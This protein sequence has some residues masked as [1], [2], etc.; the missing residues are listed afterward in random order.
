[1]PSLSE[2]QRR[3]A[4]NVLDLASEADA[5]LGV[6][7]HTI[8]ANYRSALGATYRVVRE[9]TGVPFFEAAVD[10]FVHAH[11]STGGDLNVYGDAFPAFLEA[12]P[13]AA[14]LPYLPDVAR[15]EWALDETHR[16]AD[17]GGSAQAT[18]A[19]LA[20][21]PAQDVARQR[22]ALHP[23]CRLLHCAFPVLRIWQAHQD[24]SV[25]GGKTELGGG[26]DFLLVRRED[27]RGVIERVEPGDFA[28]LAALAD[29]ADL[30]EA[31]VAALAADA[32]FD[33]GTALRTGIVNGTLTGIIA[34][35]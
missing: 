4:A 10:A 27:G 25:H 20:A 26:D 28:W 15:L 2:L 1:M 3:F 17:A 6:Y 23:S 30:A 35:G 9:L 7:R 22:F 31:L 29:G 12:Y 8:F 34:T 21:I 18:L 13:H 5:R 11:P 24:G 14:R 32:T 19:A 33:L 16:A